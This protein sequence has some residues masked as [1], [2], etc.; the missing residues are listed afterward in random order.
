MDRSVTKWKSFCHVWVASQLFSTFNSL[1]IS[2]SRQMAGNTNELHR[3]YPRNSL[4]SPTPDKGG[5]GLASLIPIVVVDVCQKPKFLM[6]IFV[7]TWSKILSFIYLFLPFRSSES[8][9]EDPTSKTPSIGHKT[10]TL[11]IKI[12]LYLPLRYR[13]QKQVY[14]LFFPFM[15]SF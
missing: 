3:N 7:V 14:E 9:L 12:K 8:F 5:P 6:S 4:S 15:A 10:K 1:P 13:C 2:T 11:R